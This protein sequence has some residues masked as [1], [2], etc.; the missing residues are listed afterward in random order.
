[1]YFSS[2]SKPIACLN[3]PNSLLSTDKDETAYKHA[4]TDTNISNYTVLNI[5]LLVNMRHELG[6][7]VG[8]SHMLF[9]VEFLF[10]AKLKVVHVLQK[11]LN[12]LHL[13]PFLIVSITHFF[14]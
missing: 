4:S 2:N 7:D 13:Q 9:E 6:G 8:W 5:F 12:M 10:L 14:C 1:M 3:K 11:L